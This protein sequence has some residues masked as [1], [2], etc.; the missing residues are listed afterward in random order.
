M[1]EE[2]KAFKDSI[3]PIPRRGYRNTVRMDGSL[4]VVTYGNR[5]TLELPAMARLKASRVS[6]DDELE[7]SERFR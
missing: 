1:R 6:D 7:L 2:L 4:D 3:W 5:N